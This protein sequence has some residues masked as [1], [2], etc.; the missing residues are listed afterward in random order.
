MLSSEV[1]DGFKNMN[2]DFVLGFLPR[3]YLWVVAK[4]LFWVINGVSSREYKS[5]EE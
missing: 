4:M 5:A 2:N 1:I 3:G